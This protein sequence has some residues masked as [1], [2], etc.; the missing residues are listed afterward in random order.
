MAKTPETLRLEREL[1]Q[2]TR[3]QGVFGC[4]EVTIG[5]F[6]SER[7]DYMTYDTKGIW[8]CYEI[9]V[10]VSDF[11]SNAKNTFIGHFNYYVMSQELYIKVKNEI[12]SHIGVYV[13]GRCVK[14][15]KKQGLRVD[16]SVLKNSLIRSLHREAEKNLRRQK[17]SQSES[18]GGEAVEDEDT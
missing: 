8:R 3:K 10:S 6:G 5:W 9:K 13:S 14:K 17:L 15:P 4:F 1:W 18:W 16:E 11:K 2:S 12:A 7:V